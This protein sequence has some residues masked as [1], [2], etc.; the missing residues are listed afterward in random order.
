MAVYRFGLRCEVYEKRVTRSDGANRD[1]SWVV[2]LARSRSLVGLWFVV[3][4]L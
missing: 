2:G 1:A 4:D 3:C